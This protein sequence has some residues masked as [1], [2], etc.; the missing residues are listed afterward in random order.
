VK[1]LP[2]ILRNAARNRRRAVLTVL[3]AAIA[4]ATLS[5]LSTI[6]AAFNAQVEVADEARLVTRN[7]T[8]LIFPL[9]LAYRERIAAVPGVKAVSLGNW[10]GGI[11]QDRKNFFAKF[12]VDA[13][14]YFPM[15]PEFG[16]PPEQYREF[17]AD[18]QGC[19]VGR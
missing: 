3:S 14:T 19:L 12:A 1:F 15:Y 13:E 16:V 5:L 6:L 11:Y 10:F 7:S 2:L 4:I 17:L 9:P 18:R 8:S